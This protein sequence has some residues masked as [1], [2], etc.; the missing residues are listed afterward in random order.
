V[1][2]LG[3]ELAH[4]PIVIEGIVIAGG[5]HDGQQPLKLDYKN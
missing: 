2:P 1:H 3:D 5:Q 4:P